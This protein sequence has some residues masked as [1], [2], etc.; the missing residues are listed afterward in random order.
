MIEKLVEELFLDDGCRCFHEVPVEPGKLLM[1]AGKWYPLELCRKRTQMGNISLDQWWM[2]VSSV[3]GSGIR[4][5]R[6]REVIIAYY[7]GLCIKNLTIFDDGAQETYILARLLPYVRGHGSRRVLADAIL[8]D[9]HRLGTKKQDLIRQLDEELARHRD[10]TM[11]LAEFSDATRAVLVP[12]KYGDAVWDRYRQ[13]AEELLG[14]GREALQRRGPEGVQ[15]PLERWQ[16]WMQSIGRHRG[17]QEEKLVLDILSYECRAALHR[18]YSA[19]WCELLPHLTQKYSLTDEA[20]WFHRFWHLM[21][22][23]ELN[24]PETY[25]HL[26]HGHVFALHPGTGLFVQSKTGADLIGQWLAAP[27]SKAA[28][29]RLLYGLFVA[30]ADYA[31]RSDL[32]RTLRI[33]DDGFATGYDLE[34]EEAR[35]VSKTKHRRLPGVRHDS[36]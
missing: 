32:A 3:Y 20:N 11:E 29:G 24:S 12:A 30:M 5:A 25:F 9:P 4:R 34:A 16:K 23:Q 8:T 7:W 18:C 35:Q 17:H 2:D 6:N 15:V 36:D 31:R 1:V 13:F 19:V 21:Q 22:C 14:E 28:F 10:K 33:K 26:F 27:E